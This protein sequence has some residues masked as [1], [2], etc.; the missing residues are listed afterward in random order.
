MFNKFVYKTL[1][2][3]FVQFRE[4]SNSLREESAQLRS[5]ESAQ[6]FRRRVHISVDQVEDHTSPPT[7]EE[8]LDNV[9]RQL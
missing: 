3:Y 7:N 8:T 2:W 1:I 4:E 5:L 9:C 6:E